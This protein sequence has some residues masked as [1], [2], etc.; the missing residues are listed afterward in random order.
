M[1][2]SKNGK[3]FSTDS[4]FVNVVSNCYYVDKSLLI[5]DLIDDCHN[6]RTMLFTRPRRFGKSLN[7]SMIQTF[8]EKT[9]KDN[10]VYFKDLDIWKCGKKYTSEQGRYPV[11]YLDLKEVEED[12][13]ADAM[14]KMKD[15]LAVEFLRHKELKTSRRVD[16]THDRDVYF[17]IA[18]K[19]ESIAELKGSLQLL[20]R[21]LYDHH[22]VKPIILIDEYDV[23]IRH[24]YEKGYYDD[25]TGFVRAF[26]SAALKG[27]NN[28]NFAVITG[29][30]RIAKESIF[31]GLNNLVVYS[32]LMDEYSQ[33]FGFTRGEVKK[34]LDDFGAPEKMDEICEWYDGYHFGNTE[35]FNPWSV[36]NYVT[37]NFAPDAY[38]VDTSGNS[39]IHDLLR[40]PSDADRRMLRD[41]M[42]DVPV[43]VKIKEKVSYGD[44]YEETD[45]GINGSI[46]SVMLA[47]GYLTPE[48]DAEG[49]RCLVIPN[50]EIKE[51]Y[52][53]E[54]LSRFWGGRGP[55]VGEE[56]KRAF[57]TGNAKLLEKTLKGYLDVSVSSLD[58]TREDTYHAFVDGLNASVTADYKVRSEEGSGL[59]RLDISYEPRNLSG[60][61]PGVVL[62]IEVAASEKDVDAEVKEAFMQME[63]MHY[64][65]K[66]KDAGVKQIDEYAVVFFGKE[67]RVVKKPQ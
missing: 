55:D 18:K 59:G 39:V 23:P 62:E 3:K 22:K 57:I 9:N 36:A 12:S 21:M 60:R 49:F 6:Y 42:N 27:N 44:L 14:D 45:E 17:K 2:V 46:Y 35:M 15:L 53:D 40:N 11:I 43:Y 8:F 63:D 7:L 66:L 50:K 19:T 34:I 13:F 5:R 51:I 30:M 1:A 54:I 65:A 67:V 10:S 4:E 52:A 31:T 28:L 48:N 33:Y 61:Y 20:S 58:L 56:I 16:K 41:L 29:A 38:W 24:G 32:I 25:I 47:S 64:A 37:Y 26:F